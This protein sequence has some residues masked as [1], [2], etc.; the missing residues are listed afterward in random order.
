[1]KMDIASPAELLHFEQADFGDGRRQAYLTF[2]N[3]SPHTITALSGRLALLDA[4]GQPVESRRVA[5]GQIGARPGASFTCHLALDGMDPFVS[6]SMLVEDVL[7]EGEDPWALHPTRLKDYRPPALEDGP[8]RIALVS[9]AGPDAVCFP[10]RFHTT[11]VCACGRFNR[12]RWGSCRRCGRQRDRTLELTPGYVRRLHSQRVQAA[13]QMP[14]QI[15]MDGAAKR[16]KNA[17]AR[18][19]RRERPAIAWGKILAAILTVAIAVL[20]VTAVIRRVGR[21]AET[22]AAVDPL[23]VPDYLEP[24]A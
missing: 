12:W 9:I 5:F 18:A 23:Y 6:A 21:Q 15:I 10:Q 3:E 2:Q 11:W 7:F 1:M 17:A 16:R 13:D 24:L 8:D 14:P 22:V 20:G 4:W 19:P